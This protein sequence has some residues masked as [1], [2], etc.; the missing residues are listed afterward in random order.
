MKKSMIG[1]LPSNKV[2][3]VLRP[4]NIDSE[5]NKIKP[6]PIWRQVL[7]IFGAITLFLIAMIVIGLLYPEEVDSVVGWI[8][9]LVMMIPIDYFFVYK[10]RKIYIMLPRKFVGAIEKYGRENLISQLTS[11]S[12]EAFY[13]EKDLYD[14][15]V[16]L[17]DDFIV[18]ANEFIYAFRDIKMISFYED[19]YSESNANKVVDVYRREVMK[20][21]YTA[22]ITMNDGSHKKESFAIRRSDIKTFI[23]ALRRRSPDAIFR[24]PG[25]Y[26]SDYD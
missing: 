8:S 6:H 5:G 14:S 15:L 3:W 23:D 7:M 1:R 2:S 18:S 21:V 12:A 16:I 24:C 17:T 9:L 19:N 25:L 20:N 26:D 11:S 10:Y 13:V 4:S 22:I